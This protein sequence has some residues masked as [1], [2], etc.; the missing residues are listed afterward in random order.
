M[1]SDIG[2]KSTFPFSL[3]AV[4]ADWSLCGL[5]KVWM[6]AM[7]SVEYDI[8]VISRLQFAKAR[9]TLCPDILL[10]KSVGTVDKQVLILASISSFKVTD[11]ICAAFNESFRG[12]YALLRRRPGDRLQHLAHISKAKAALT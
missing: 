12:S 7:E 6:D 1:H 2:L 9:I 4:Q 10:G 11:D 3:L 5:S 8:W